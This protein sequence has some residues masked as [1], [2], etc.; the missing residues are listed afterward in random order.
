MNE[1]ND[2]IVKQKESVLPNF[3][4]NHPN[5]PMIPQTP[6]LTGEFKI[7]T[8]LRNLKKETILQEF[9]NPKDNKH[10][11]EIQVGYQFS[12]LQNLGPCTSVGGIANLIKGK[13]D[14]GLCEQ[15]L[16]QFFGKTPLQQLVGKDWYDNRSSHTGFQVIMLWMFAMRH[17]DENGAFKLLR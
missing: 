9:L 3:T 15:E 12:K 8:S 10:E 4:E 2:E 16:L 1:G 17:E 14:R 13:L 5:S 7:V 6:T 11:R